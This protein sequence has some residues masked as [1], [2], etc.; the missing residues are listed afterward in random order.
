MTGNPLPAS[1]RDML[2]SMIRQVEAASETARRVRQINRRLWQRNFYLER[3]PT[4]YCITDRDSTLCEAMGL[5]LCE[6]E[7]WTTEHVPQGRPR[8]C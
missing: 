2:A 4:G 6:A 7:A 1:E 8:A 5:S 3:T